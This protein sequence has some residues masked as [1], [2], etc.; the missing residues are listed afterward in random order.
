M[1]PLIVVDITV[2]PAE[3]R[4]TP[5]VQHEPVDIKTAAPKTHLTCFSRRRPV[6]DELFNDEDDV[7]IEEEYEYEDVEASD[8]DDEDVEEI[9][10][11]DVDSVVASL[12][13]LNEGIQS[14]NI[15]L[16]IENA[17]DEILHLVYTDDELLGVDDEDEFL[18]EAA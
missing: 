7:E 12:N 5:S 1:E 10:S 15:R 14:E 11:D 3:R 2:D 6:S 13:E 16:V 17:I 9:S 18:E 8:D 4:R